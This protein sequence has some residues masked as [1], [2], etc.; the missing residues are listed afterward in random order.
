MAPRWTRPNSVARNRPGSSIGPGR[1]RRVSCVVCC[2][3]Q[4]GREI[5][6]ADELG[7]VSVRVLA[8][9]L[10]GQRLNGRPRRRALE[11]G[12]AEQ[13]AELRDRRGEPE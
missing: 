11:F 5:H 7:A 12:V 10:A 13:H 4:R 8:T 9:V 1:Y 2:C 3:L 6:E